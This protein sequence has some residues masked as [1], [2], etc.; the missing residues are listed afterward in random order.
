MCG[1]SPGTVET[2]SEQVCIPLE[3]RVICIDKCIHHIISALNAGG[4]RTHA[5]CCGH[6]DL[7]GNI[8]L[9]DGRWIGIFESEE[10]WVAANN[11]VKAKDGVVITY[12]GISAKD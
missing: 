5:C 2:Y 4:V 10:E 7:I 11:A 6:N 9:E 1:D 12:A 3:G 8:V